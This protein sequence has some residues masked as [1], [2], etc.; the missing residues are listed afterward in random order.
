MVQLLSTTERESAHSWWVSSVGAEVVHCLNIQEFM[1]KCC[2]FARGSMKK[3]RSDTF[4]AAVSECR[5][6]PKLC[7]H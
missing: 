2:L 4:Y 1:L 6:I 5:L 3:H 7:L